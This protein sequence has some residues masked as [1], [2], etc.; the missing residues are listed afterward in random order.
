MADYMAARRQQAAR[1]RFEARELLI[2]LKSKPCVKC[3]NSFHHCQMDLVRPDGGG[4]S[5]ASLLLKS[6]R[7]MLDEAAVRLRLCANCNRLRDYN[8]KRSAMEGEV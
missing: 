2:L 6:K 3:R 5:M 4:P 7:R 1:R 8:R